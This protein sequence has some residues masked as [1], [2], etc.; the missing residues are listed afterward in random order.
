MTRMRSMV[1]V[2]SSGV[3]R[4]VN[5]IVKHNDPTTL[6]CVIICPQQTRDTEQIYSTINP[7]SATLA[8]KLIVFS[9]LVQV[10]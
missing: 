1:N 7:Q 10:L 4:N 3:L 9:R 6:I 2:Q 5:I 8:Q